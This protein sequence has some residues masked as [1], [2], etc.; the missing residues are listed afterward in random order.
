MTEQIT[1]EV[2]KAKWVRIPYE[3]VRVEW[4]NGTAHLLPIDQVNPNHFPN[5]RVVEEEKFHQY[6]ALHAELSA[7]QGALRRIE[8]SQCSRLELKRS[9]LRGKHAME[10]VERAVERAM[11]LELLD[12]GK[13]AERISQQK[14]RNQNKGRA[15]IKMELQQKGIS[16]KD[17]NAAIAHF[18]EEDEY[19]NALRWARS[20][21]NGIKGEGR[22]KAVRFARKLAQRGFS[23]T[24]IRKVLGHFTSNLDNDEG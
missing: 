20:K 24:I 1:Y 8:R 3:A 23:S 5:G 22:D 21:W 6:V 9:L 11:A 19:V 15:R 16:A 14:F 7:W 4:T 2:A 18:T 17:A 13:L 12:D 10:F